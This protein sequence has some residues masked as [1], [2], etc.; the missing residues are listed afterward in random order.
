MKIASTASNPVHIIA[1]KGLSIYEAPE[2]TKQALRQAL[3]RGF[4]VE[5]DVQRIKD[6][7]YV[8]VHDRYLP[9]PDNEEFKGRTTL[10]SHYGNGF[11]LPSGRKL[12]TDCT[13]DELLT[14]AVFDQARLEAALTRH[15]GEKVHLTVTEPPRIATLE[16][17]ILLLKQFPNSRTF[18][19][20]KRPDTSA[21]YNDGLEEKIIGMLCDGGLIP[22]VI[23]N[24]CNLSTLG[25]VRKAS[26]QIELSIDTDYADIPNLAHNMD[27]AQRLIDEFGLGF[28]NPPFSDVDRKL[29]EDAQ[30]IE[31][32][33]AT[34]VQNETKREELAE[35]RRLKSIGVE[36]LFTDQAE[37]ALKIF[38]RNE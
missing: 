12:V 24:T 9:G 11:Y 6:G 8:L 3:E 18:L 15:A 35:I 23:I 10:E 7:R 32:K 31:L 5:T 25:N 29:L 30:R 34:W 33:V 14:E 19:E 36:Y 4:W 16:E 1:H 20:I 37:E 26:P 21:N 22:N 38:T 13:L 27:E 28:W 17:L 2:N